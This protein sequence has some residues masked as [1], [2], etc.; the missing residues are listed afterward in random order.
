MFRTKWSKLKQSDK[1]KEILDIAQELDVQKGKDEILA[2]KRHQSVEA[3]LDALDDGKIE[4]DLRLPDLL[5]PNQKFTML[6]TGEHARRDSYLA[7]CRA[8]FW[9]KAE[10]IKETLRLAGPLRGKDLLLA[11]YGPWKLRHVVRAILQSDMKALHEISM[12]ALDADR[13]ADILAHE[14][15]HSAKRAEELRHADLLSE[16]DWVAIRVMTEQNWDYVRKSQVAT[17]YTEM[18]EDG[19]VR[20]K[21]TFGRRRAVL[22]KRVEGMCER[23]G[24]TI[25]DGLSKEEADQARQTVWTLIW[26]ATY[27]PHCCK[28]CGVVLAFHKE[29]KAA[30]DRILA[31]G[32]KILSNNITFDAIIPRVQGGDYSLPNIQPLCS[33]CQCFKWYLSQTEAEDLLQKFKTAETLNPFHEEDLIRPAVVLPHHNPR[34]M[35]TVRNWASAQYKSIQKKVRAK[36]RKAGNITLQ[37]LEMMMLELMVGENEYQDPTGMVLNVRLAQIDRIDSLEGY[38]LSNCRVIYGGLNL[39]RNNTI[40]DI[41]IRE[42]KQQVRSSNQDAWEVEE[43]DFDFEDMELALEEE[44]VALGNQ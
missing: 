21:K 32:N 10:K 26:R 38:N 23:S 34:D 33:G 14:W 11:K 28:L 18:G 15:A 36:P 39:F 4:D 29:V 1:I 20:P 8:D 44:I 41:I 13:L 6:F 19:V 42:Y 17:R 43:E 37:D 5:F 12:L 40:G 7:E 30:P 24:W 2:T 3:F 35:T 25:E 16:E 31:E 22:K 9:E 27:E